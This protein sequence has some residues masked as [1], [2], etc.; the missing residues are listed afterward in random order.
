MLLSLPT[1]ARS[2]RAPPQGHR[3]RKEIPQRFAAGDLW[4]YLLLIQADLVIKST[5]P[6]EDT[7]T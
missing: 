5:V 1:A 7:S 3:R 4:E 2:Q 6:A